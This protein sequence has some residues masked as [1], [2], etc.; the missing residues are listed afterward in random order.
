MVETFELTLASGDVAKFSIWE[1]AFKKE[2]CYFAKMI[3]VKRISPKNNYGAILR[4]GE[5]TI[6]YTDAA[7]LKADLITLYSAET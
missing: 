1:S 3:L 2:T 7:K 5:K 6:Y 4:E